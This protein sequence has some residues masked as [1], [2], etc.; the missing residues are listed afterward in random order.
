VADGVQRQQPEFW[1]EHE[2]DRPAVVDGDRILSYAQWNEQADRLAAA[3]EEFPSAQRTVGVRMHQSAAWFV[4]NLALAK[5]GRELLAVNWRLTPHEAGQI[6][7]DSGIE[8]L[9]LDDADTGPIRSALGGQQVLLVPVAAAAAE[10]GTPSFETLA[11]G[12]RRKSYASREPTPMVVYSSGTTGRPKG[13]RNPVPA[14]A[15][16]RQ[17]LLEYLGLSEPV[18]E[19]K[20]A[21]MVQVPRTLLTLP[22]HHGIGPKSARTCHERGGTVYLLDRFDPVRVLELIDRHR[23]THWTTV[24][25]MLQRIRV[26]PPE[27]LGS[28]DVSS[29]RVLALGSAPSSP[30]LRDWVQGYFGNCL[31][32]GYGAA[33]VG[34]VTYMRPGWR[35]AKPGSCGRPRK[36][37]S[38][39]IAG[40]DGASVPPGTEGEIYVRTPVTIRNYANAEPLDA[41]TVTSDGHFRTGDYGRLDEDGFLYITGRVKDM[42]IAGGVNIFPAEIEHALAEHPDVI[43]AAVFGVPEETFGEQVMAVCETRPGST[44]TGAELIAFVSGRLAPF[45]R[46][47][48]VELVDELPRNAMNKVVKTELRQRHWDGNPL[49]I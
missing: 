24:P 18:P 17:V 27:V 13:V 5:L 11:A 35:R 9:F 25:T 45:K 3:I 29:I 4:I 31:F 30:E 42:I 49:A 33:E 40:P 41:A 14:S 37:V 16:E 32:E 8:I 39:R 43:E 12:P 44:V 46:P 34:M 28:F 23:I 21:R 47:R 7:A 20:A 19:A 10:P 36:H 26:L 48:I 38:V 6:A 22:L 1:A 2:P 15:E